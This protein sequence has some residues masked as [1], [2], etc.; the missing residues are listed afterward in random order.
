M[1]KTSISPVK[2]CCV[3]FGIWVRHIIGMQWMETKQGGRE[4]M[5]V[6]CRVQW[7]GGGEA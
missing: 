7:G 2:G 3:D 6:S 1:W 5:C 4:V